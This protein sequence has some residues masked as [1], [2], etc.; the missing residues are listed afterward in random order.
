MYKYIWVKDK[1]YFYHSSYKDYNLAKKEA[2]RFRKK[3]ASRYFIVSE[4]GFFKL[5]MDKTIGLWN[6]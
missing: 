6:K 3:N 1:K 5:F 2:K 4:N